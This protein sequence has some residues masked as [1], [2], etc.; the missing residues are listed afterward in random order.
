MTLL[1]FKVPVDIKS[2]L[3]QTNYHDWIGLE[4]MYVLS[5][6]YS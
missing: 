2:I 6:V 4:S 1:P 5:Y 3:Y